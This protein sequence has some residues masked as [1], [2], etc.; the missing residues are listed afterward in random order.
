MYPEIFGVIKSYGLM[1]ALSFVLGLML[2]I[3]RGRPY[4]LSSETITDLIFTCLVSSI[5][6]VRLFYVL[7]HLG[8]FHPWYRAFFIWDGGLTLYGGILGSIFAVWY[9]TRRKGI[10][11]LVIADIFSPGVILGIGI[12]RIGCFLAGCCFGM[13][14]NCSCAM[15]FPAA[16]PASKLFGQVPVHPAQLYGS[17]AGFIIFA[18]LLL[19]ERVSNYRGAT[20]GR[21]LFLY[22]LARFVIDFSRYYEPG[23]VMYLGWSNNQWI[24]LGFMI[25]GTIFMVLGARGKL[26]GP[27]QAKEAQ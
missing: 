7:S 25:A 15:T 27:W 18:L 21:F 10:P 16:A 5:I 24:S 23:Q 11:Y 8:D 1:L 6:G 12:T 17:L 3:R 14:S 22:G 2:S 26:G 19:L 9:M 13:P 20:F 4:N